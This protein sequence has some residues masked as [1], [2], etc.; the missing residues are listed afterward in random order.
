M[1]LDSVP[2]LVAAVRRVALL[3]DEQLRQL[4]A[5]VHADADSLAGEL[6]GRSWLTQYQARQLLCGHGDELV[7]GP[8]LVLDRLGRGGMGQVYKAR[9]RPMNRV[10]A[11]KVVRPDLV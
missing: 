6:V 1:P 10:V 2:A 3:D 11:L 8:Y 9:H 5:Q 4:A 7:L